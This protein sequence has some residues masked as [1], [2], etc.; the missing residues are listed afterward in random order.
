MFLAYP[1]QVDALLSLK[2]LYVYMS[3]LAQTIST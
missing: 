1:V 2:T 3:A